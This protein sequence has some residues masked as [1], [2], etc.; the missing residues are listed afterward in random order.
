M[1]LIKGTQSLQYKIELAV[2]NMVDTP[3]SRHQSANERLND[4]R[5]H[6]GAFMPSK[7]HFYPI[8]SQPDETLMRVWP[9]SG[10]VTP[11]WVGSSLKL[12][13]PPSSSR[14]IPVRLW[15]FDVLPVPVEHICDC[16]VDISQGLL[17]L[18][19]VD[20]IDV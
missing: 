2:A 9:V 14:H 4:L 18:V 8:V 11:Y 12:F 7:M 10:G 3:S 16:K 13:R 17:V 19:T 5:T 1:H 6:Q 20:L 15:I